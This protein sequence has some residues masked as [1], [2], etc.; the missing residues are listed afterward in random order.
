MYPTYRDGEDVVIRKFNTPKINDV[1][2]LDCLSKCSA[3]VSVIKRDSLPEPLSRT[4]IKRIIKINS[5]GCY[6]VEGDNRNYSTDSREYGWL[7]PS[8]IRVEGVVEGVV[9]TK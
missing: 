9:V 7:C 2:V 3:G 8:D 5:K 4:L 6:W 1:I